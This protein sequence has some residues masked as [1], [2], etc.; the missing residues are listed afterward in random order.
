MAA[1]IELIQQ[2]VDDGRLPSTGSR[3]LWAGYGRDLPCSACDAKIAPSEIE[4]EVD[5]LRFHGRCYDIWKWV[6]PGG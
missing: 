1:L 2:K 3:K 5:G 6:R 4:Y